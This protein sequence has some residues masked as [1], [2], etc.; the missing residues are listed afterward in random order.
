MILLGRDI[1]DLGDF[2]K[3]CKKVVKSQSEITSYINTLRISLQYH[4]EQRTL[5]YC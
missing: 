2:L 3:T 1:S 4:N 5:D